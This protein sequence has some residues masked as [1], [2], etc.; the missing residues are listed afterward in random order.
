MN[1]PN[2]FMPMLNNVGGL[3]VPHK[4]TVLGKSSSPQYHLLGCVQKEGTKSA[5][6]QMVHNQIGQGFQEDT[7]VKGIEAARRLRK[8]RRVALP[9]SRSLIRSSAKAPKVV[10]VPTEAQLKWVK[11]IHFI[12]KPWSCKVIA[13]LNTFPRNGIVQACL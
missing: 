1:S 7:M 4:A 8:T 9:L 13:C 5:Q 10:S 6:D 2:S 3:S 12:R 11:I